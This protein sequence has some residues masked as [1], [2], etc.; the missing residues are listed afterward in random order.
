MLHNEYTPGMTA[1][2]LAEYGRLMGLP[3]SQYP[4]AAR[5]YIE[6]RRPRN[7]DHLAQVVAEWVKGNVA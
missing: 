6:S 2:Q 5:K 1:A 4:E 3:G 7:G